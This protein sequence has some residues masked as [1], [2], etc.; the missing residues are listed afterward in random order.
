[1]TEKST[2]NSKMTR[3]ELYKLAVELEERLAKKGA[4]R[5]EEVLNLMGNGFNTI[6]SIAAELKTTTKNISSYLSYIR[7]DLKSKGSTIISHKIDN[8]TYLAQV[9]FKDLGWTVK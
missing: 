8:Q 5:K 7:T 4:G 6:E 1:M 9:S 2:I 3:E